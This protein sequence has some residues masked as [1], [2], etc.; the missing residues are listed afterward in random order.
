MGDILFLA[1]HVPFPPDRAAR[2]FHILR[3][4][5]GLTRVHLIAL[6]RDA[7]EAEAAAALRPLL[8]S[9][10]VEQRHPSPL[11]DA[12]R[13]L[14]GGRAVTLAAG[15]GL[16]M[17]GTVAW[18]LDREPIEAIF[19]AGGVMAQ[20]VPEGGD[21]RVVVDFVA[22][23]SAGFAA[24]AE[25]ESGP[26]RW[27]HNREARL[28]AAFEAATAA[29]A[30]AS[31]LASAEEAA[32]FREAT[33]AARVAVL[34]QGVD[35]EHYDPL[36][37]FARLSPEDRGG[38]PLLLFDGRMDRRADIEAV[39]S[40]VRDSFPAIRRRFPRTR[41][42][43]VGRH[44]T[45]VVRALERDSHIFV[46]GAVADRR[47]WLAAAD[48]VVAPL[49]FAD[50]LRPA[51]LEAMAMVRPVV[52]S[53]AACSGIDATPGVHL[54]LADAAEEADAVAGLLGDRRRARELGLAGR[55][56]VE[57]RYGWDARLAPLAGILGY[58]ASVAG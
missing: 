49:R 8:A 16:G 11:R 7:A 46:T 31:L 19:V 15:D 22:R 29:R 47:S 28:L 13:A 17:R 50:G 38:G 4:L 18:L 21:W 14:I 44:P 57:A 24:C 5:A 53:P 54:L 35:A 58:E 30:D 55:A 3:H 2:T 32:L 39:E 27:F 33:G 40:F 45:P 6:A 26:L 25:R 56:R 9:L 1:P 43:I 37:D 23:H 41:L 12:A 34:E 42:A 36:G 52:A 48:V 10:H 20:G 51:V